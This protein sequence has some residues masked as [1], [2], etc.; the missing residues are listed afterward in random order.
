VQERRNGFGLVA[1][2]LQDQRRDGHEMADHRHLGLL[3]HLTGVQP[4]GVGEGFA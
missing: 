3:A 1:S 2:V 4:C